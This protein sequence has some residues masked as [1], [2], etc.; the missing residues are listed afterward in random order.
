MSLASYSCCRQPRDTCPARIDPPKTMAP[1]TTAELALASRA[2]ARVAAGASWAALVAAAALGDSEFTHVHARV[3]GDGRLEGDSG[4]ANGYR[5]VVQSYPR[6]SLSPASVPLLR[7][8]P[9]GSLQ[10]AVTPEELKRGV[11]VDLVHWGR[12]RLEGA[13]VVAWVEPGVPDLEFDGL[14]ARPPADAWY[15][16]ADPDAPVVVLRRPAA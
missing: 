8:K 9:L 7:A 1:P 15:G 10:R 12:D 13:A 4:A 6:S 16:A 2:R 5:L 14:R 11:S 3:V